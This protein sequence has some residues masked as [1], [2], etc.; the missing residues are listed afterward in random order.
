MFGI[1]LAKKSLV[2]S[3]MD[4]SKFCKCFPFMIFYEIFI[5]DIR[6][7]IQGMCAIIMFDVTS[8]ITYRS[9]PNWHRFVFVH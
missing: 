3:E 9:V 7:S 5:I 8:R 4:T 1:R 2:V 6:C